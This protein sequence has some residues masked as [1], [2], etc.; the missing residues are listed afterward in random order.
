MIEWRV[1]NGAAS[2]CLCKKGEEK[3][4]EGGMVSEAEEGAPKEA[5]FPG[6]WNHAD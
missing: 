5:A 2:Q 1:I 4:L 3:A 6:R